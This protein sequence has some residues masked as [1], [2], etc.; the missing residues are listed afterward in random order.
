METD[1]R[2]ATTPVLRARGLFVSLFFNDVFPCVSE[3]LI[4]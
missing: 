1:E 3:I 2:T 4:F